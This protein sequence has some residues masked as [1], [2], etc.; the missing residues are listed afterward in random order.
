MIRASVFVEQADSKRSEG[1][2]QQE[3]IRKFQGEVFNV[4]VATSIGKKI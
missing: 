1:M 4:R 3:T 2:N